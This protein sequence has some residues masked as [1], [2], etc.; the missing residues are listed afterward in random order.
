MMPSNHPG[1]GMPAGHIT[2]GQLLPSET[3]KLDNL[4]EEVLER[5]FIFSYSLNNELLCLICRSL[6]LN[7]SW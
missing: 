4:Q 7:Q 6:M 5:G 1:L 2:G 3:A